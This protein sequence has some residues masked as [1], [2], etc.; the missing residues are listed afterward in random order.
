[1]LRS[2]TNRKNNNYSDA[3]VKG[4]EDVENI[5]VELAR[6]DPELVPNSE[7]IESSDPVINKI[8][9]REFRAMS[10]APQVPPNSPTVLT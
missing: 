8:Y 4:E 6:L 2:P 9:N 5:S 7:I 10:Y 3:N 1:M